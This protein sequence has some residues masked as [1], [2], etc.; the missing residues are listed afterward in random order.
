M[1]N[2]VTTKRNDTGAMQ[3]I[4]KAE[5]VLG[6]IYP[7]G[8]CGSSFTG[9][10]TFILSSLQMCQCSNTITRLCVE[11]I[12]AATSLYFTNKESIPVPTDQIFHRKTKGTLIPSLSKTSLHIN[13]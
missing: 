9:S 6:L 5:Q 13:I 11:E 8:Q 7:I 2:F 1:T 4:E 10:P 3:Q 12:K